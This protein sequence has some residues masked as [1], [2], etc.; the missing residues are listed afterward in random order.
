MG[1]MIYGL[2]PIP[3]D[4]LEGQ[5]EPKRKKMSRE[6]RIKMMRTA[7]NSMDFSEKET[8]HG[9]ILSWIARIIVIIFATIGA[10]TFFETLAKWITGAL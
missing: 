2:P 10:H 1:G 9:S 8:Y 4:H 7:S 5:P 6:E 3:G